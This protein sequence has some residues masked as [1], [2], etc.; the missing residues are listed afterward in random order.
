MIPYIDLRARQSMYMEELKKSVC[1]VLDSGQYIGGEHVGLI[2]SAMADLFGVRYGVAVGNGT[3]AL[4][5]ALQVAGVRAGMEVVI[6][7]FSFFATIGA[8]LRLRATPVIVDVR[9]DRPLM[10][11]S[12]L[13]ERIGSNTAAIVPVH[14]FGDFVSVSFDGC[15]IVDDASQAL[16]LQRARFNGHIAALSFYP[17]K[18]LGA[19]GDAGMVLTPHEDTAQSV[20]Q[21]ANHGYVHGRSFERICGHSG[22]N[23]RMD[24]I[25]A[26][27]LRV[28]LRYLEQAIA[29]RRTIAHRY[30]EAFAG[31]ALKRDDDSAIPT[32]NITHPERDRVQ[33]ELAEDGIGTKI[34]YPYTLD[35]LPVFRGESAPNA[36]RFSKELLALPCHEGLSEEEISYIIDKVS[37]RL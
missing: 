32:Y 22:Y 8:V 2:E 29:K 33:R 20:R 35:Q 25:Q 12:K 34:Y 21:L 11:T 10:D 19:M 23:S 14:L 26:V 16:N 9:E 5:L 30:D 27:G 6:P 28:S 37:K 13:F 18:V 36:H 24:A 4:T 15:P 7:A 3:D 31:A 1:A 17:T